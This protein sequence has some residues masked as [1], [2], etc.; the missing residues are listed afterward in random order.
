[1][2]VYLH[3]HCTVDGEALVRLWAVLAA[4]QA[5]RSTHSASAC[6]AQLG[7]K[8]ATT[9]MTT[10]TPSLQ[11][12]PLTLTSACLHP[13]LT[14]WQSPVLLVYIRYIALPR[15]LCPIANRTPRAYQSTFRHTIAL[16]LEDSSRLSHSPPLTASK[17][18]TTHDDNVYPLSRSRSMGAI[19][20]RPSR[21]W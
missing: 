2:F 19:P 20:S 7:E 6:P 16:C 4:I 10:T 13:Y 15:V 3:T 1:M 14:T 9:T 5:P 18:T 8:V 17:S 21:H 12:S 11:T